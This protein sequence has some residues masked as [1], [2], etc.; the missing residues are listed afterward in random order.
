MNVTR[1]PSGPLAPLLA[2]VL[3]TA[4]ASPAIPGEPEASQPSSA[5]DQPC[6]RVGDCPKVTCECEE[7]TALGVAACDTEKTHCC[8]SPST[9][10]ERFCEVNHQKWTG[11]SAATPPDERAPIAQDASPGPS[12]A[13][14]DEP[15]TEGNDCRTIT[16]QC[17]H[18]T[19]AD[20]AACSAE[21][22]CCG[23]TQVV[24]DHFCRGKKGKWTG[25]VV[26]VAPPPNGRD[27]LGMPM[28]DA[29]PSDPDDLEP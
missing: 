7:A 13:P 10:C 11:R 23:D 14:C 9:A 5:C 19:A 16:C 20:V 22:H 4:I 25:K 21:T 15:C 29:A 12:A 24:C 6:K 8:M 2:V 1:R 27:W 28:N 26:E 18:G 17:A 3:L